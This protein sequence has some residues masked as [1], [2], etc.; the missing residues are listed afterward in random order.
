M[1]CFGDA[2]GKALCL[3]K[4]P[5]GNAFGFDKLADKL[6]ARSTVRCDDGCSNVLQRVEM[7]FRGSKGLTQLVNGGRR[8]VGGLAIGLNSVRIYC[9]QIK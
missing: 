9:E 1:F 3:P 7:S 5:G 4:L 6:L 2:H 8:I